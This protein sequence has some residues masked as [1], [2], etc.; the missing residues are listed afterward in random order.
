VRERESRPVGSAAAYGRRGALPVNAGAVPGT[1][2]LQ[3]WDVGQGTAC[4]IYTIIT[5]VIGSFLLHLKNNGITRCV[6]CLCGIMYVYRYL[7]ICLGHRANTLCY[8]YSE[9]IQDRVPLL[10][11]SK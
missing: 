9:H 5:G 2:L 4:V 1:R 7:F 10:P 6:V 3:H 8:I 11:H